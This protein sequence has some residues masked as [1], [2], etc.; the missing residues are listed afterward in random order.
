MQLLVIDL[1]VVF[2]SFL[3]NKLLKCVDLLLFFVSMMINLECLGFGL[4]VRQ[5][6]QL[7]D[8]TLSVFSDL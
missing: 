5:Q 7:D 8:V 3:P 1:H 4:L 2:Q 6:N